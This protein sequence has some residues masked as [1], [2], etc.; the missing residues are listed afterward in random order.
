MITILVLTKQESLSAAVAAVVDPRNYKLIAKE[1]VREAES[2]LVRGAIDIA[3]VDVELTDIKAIRLLQDLKQIAPHVPILIYTGSKQWE[4]EE[5]AYL[6]GV[7]HVL[8]KPVRGK[9]LNTL[10]ERVAPKTDTTPAERVPGADSGRP[11]ADPTVVD[12][13]RALEALRNFS[14]ILTHSLEPQSLL[15]KFLLLLRQIVGVNRAMIFLRK[16]STDTRDD[17]TSADERWMRCAC[18]IGL[19]QT[20]LDHFA[21]TINSGIGG[22]L[23]RQ[24][25]ILRAGGQE[26]RDQREILKEFQLLGVEV[27]IPILDRESLIGVAVLDA[28]LTGEPYSN[29]ELALIFH[30]LE[31]VG[32]AIKNSW[33]HTHL[34]ANHE[35][36]V[37]I[38][39]QLGSG[40][41]VIGPNMSILH[42][43][44]AS[45]SLFQQPGN[46]RRPIEFQDIPQD[47]GSKIFAVLK[48]GMAVPPFKHGFPPRP[49]ST[50]QVSI[51]PFQTKGTK[52][53]SA[54]LLVIEDITQLARTQKLEIEASNLRLVK[55]M[56]EHL[57]HEIN[58]SLVPVSTHQQLLEERFDDPDF[59]ESLDE[60]LEEGVRRIGRLA[61]QMM[62]LARDRSDFRDKIEVS[63]LIEEAFKE[64]NHYHAS[65]STQLRLDAPAGAGI[66]AG[67]R[68][69]LKH[70]LLE[71]LLN[72]LQANPAK[73]DVS[74]RLEK[75]ED[76]A[77]LHLLHI[78]VTDSGSG[79]TPEAHLKAAT[80][81]FSTRTVGLGLGLTVTR[82]IVEEHRGHLELE[83]ANGGGKGMVRISLPLSGK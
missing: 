34:R 22:F 62:F 67:D 19:E 31:E 47:L 21:L 24:G 53:P 72:A 60:A 83:P 57:A 66:V 26:A 23:Y 45:K 48:T 36:L 74:V 49:Q 37:D 64:A 51:S 46:E 75:K 8:N 11:R 81:F 2:L 43:N 29:E 69:A 32:L 13:P 65:K 16:P 25:R 18:A 54:A 73:P 27:A 61:N 80:P 30:M 82:K 55:A 28:R 4:W 38:L 33:L 7:E 63:E 12:Q 59:R 41:M 76:P 17:S 5:D 42:A 39:G 9:L 52:T 58:N 6:L 71:V 50:F 1:D 78:E 10:L 77:G 35:M 44:P 3:L 15:K 56:A 79:F 70:A 40:C 68:K 14:T 20:L